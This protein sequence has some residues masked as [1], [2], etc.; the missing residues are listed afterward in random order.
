MRQA[1]WA[2]HRD[3]GVL[4]AGGFRR[5]IRGVGGAAGCRRG[6]VDQGLLGLHG[7]G[8]SYPGVGVGVRLDVGATWWCVAVVLRS[9][10]ARLLAAICARDPT[11][12]R[13]WIV[14]VR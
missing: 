10:A 5:D 1:G 4:A 6:R 3:G 14:M 8:A 13:R 7:A 12:L 9:C 11:M 2:L